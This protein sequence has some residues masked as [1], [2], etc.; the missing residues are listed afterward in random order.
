MP[1]GRKRCDPPLFRRRLNFRPSF[2]A[3]PRTSS[4]SVTSSGCR[5]ASLGLASSS[6]AR[7]TAPVGREDTSRAGSAGRTQGIVL[8]SAI[9]NLQTA[10]FAPMNDAA[11]M[12]FL[13][14]LHRRAGPQ[15]PRPRENRIMVFC[16]RS[17]GPWPRPRPPRT[18]PAGR[19]RGRRAS[20]DLG[21]QD[22]Q[23]GSRR[24]AALVTN[25]RYARAS[26]ASKSPPSRR[27]DVRYSGLNRRLKGWRP[28]PRGRDLRVR[29]G[30]RGDQRPL[31]GRPRRLRPGRA[32]VQ[33]RHALR[34]LGATSGP[35]RYGNVENQYLNTARRCAS[36]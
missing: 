14:D 6:S 32:R 12:L 22:L 4:L 8:I 15:R 20:E 30:Q 5:P 28:R 35:G 21:A 26:R 29:P 31:P 3:T 1:G 7:A 19:A 25:R 36:P 17:R 11:Y 16:P 9:L 24:Q 33:E 27:G 2:R 10:R 34:R 23:P 13:P 18:D